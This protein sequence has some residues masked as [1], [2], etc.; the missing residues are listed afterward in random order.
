MT[1]LVLHHQNSRPVSFI[2][3]LNPFRHLARSIY[4]LCLTVDFAS[5]LLL[6]SRRHSKAWITITLSVIWCCPSYFP[7]ARIKYH[8]QKQLEGEQGLLWLTVPE[9]KVVWLGS[10]E[11]TFQRHTGRRG[12]GCEVLQP[13]PLAVYFLQQGSTTSRNSA[14]SWRPSVQT[15]ELMGEDFAHLNHKHCFIL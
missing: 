15:R 10:K 12:A 11:I 8:G 6:R 13:A 5:V 1:G 14:T 7:L 9:G 4:M 3:N 2:V